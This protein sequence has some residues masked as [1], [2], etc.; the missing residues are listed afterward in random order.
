MKTIL[1]ITMGNSPGTRVFFDSPRF[2]GEIIESVLRLITGRKLMPLVVADNAS[3]PF[4]EDAGIKVDQ[5]VATSPDVPAEMPDWA[6]VTC[7]APVDEP[8]LVISPFWGVVCSERMEAFLESADK[9]RWSLSAHRVHGNVN[10]FW[11]KM[12]SPLGRLDRNTYV[13]RN[14]TFL[15]KF[16]RDSGIMN[17]E[18][19][20]QFMGELEIHGSQWLPELY[21]VDG[22]FA[23]LQGEMNNSYVP[24]VLDDPDWESLPLLYQLPIFEM[25]RDQEARLE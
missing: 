25:A 8:V 23:L 22:A 4:A 7:G 18:R 16:T 9:S 11:M 1:N 13:D 6:G 3:L 17:K 12:I 24:V 14:T 21:R 10:P 20:Q 5:I 2:L 19:W 15:P